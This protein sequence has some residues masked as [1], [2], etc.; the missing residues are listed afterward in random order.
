VVHGAADSKV[1]PLVPFF[2]PATAGSAGTRKV[3]HNELLIFCALFSVTYGR[4]TVFA[5][6]ASAIVGADH[7]A[8]RLS[9]QEL[10]G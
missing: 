7:Y 10:R 8:S 5:L 1:F 3:I 9:L 6:F 2:I 4:T